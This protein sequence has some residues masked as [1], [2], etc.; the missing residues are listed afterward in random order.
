MG[1]EFLTRVNGKIILGVDHEAHFSVKSRR[2][3]KFFITVAGGGRHHTF[4]FWKKTPRY[5]YS[6]SEWLKNEKFF[7]RK[8]LNFLIWTWSLWKIFVFFYEVVNSWTLKTS[9]VGLRSKYSCWC[10]ISWVIFVFF[11]AG[12]ELSIY[13]WI[14]R[15]CDDN[16]ITI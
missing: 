2:S 4:H 3:E 5:Q 8:V 9:L 14:L 1:V 10:W 6:S 15:L 16:M 7:L 13:E 11:V 12:E